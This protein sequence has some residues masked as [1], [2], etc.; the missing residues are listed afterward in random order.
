MAFVGVIVAASFMVA[1]KIDPTGS[2]NP[3]VRC[4][5]IVVWARKPRK[6]SG[7]C[8]LVAGS[9]PA[10]SY[11]FFVVGSFAAVDQSREDIAW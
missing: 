2:A 6:N 4:G 9:Y 11:S 10:C 7:E 5:K 3:A 8:A 1:A